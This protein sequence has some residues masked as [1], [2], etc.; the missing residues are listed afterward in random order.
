MKILWNL[1]HA[2]GAHP[3]L[4]VLGVALVLSTITD[5]RSRKISNSVT[6]SAALIGI[7]LHAVTGGGWLALSSGLGF[8]VWLIGGMLVWQTGGLGAGDVKMVA[9]AGALLGLL[10]AF[11]MYFLSNLIQ[12]VYLFGRWAVQGT[13]ADNFRLLG[14]WL[15]SIVSPGTKKIHFKPVGMEDRTPHAPFMLLGV[16]AMMALSYYGVLPW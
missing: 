6:F 9:A 8:L 14:S 11:W 13:L 4:I 15:Y 10:G 1:N 12:V 5:L 3:A 2:P 16:V 7:V